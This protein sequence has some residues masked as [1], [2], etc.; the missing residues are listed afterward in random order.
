MKNFL[1][2]LAAGLFVAALSGSVT[3]VAVN[4][5]EGKTKAV[6]SAALGG[7][8]VGVAAYFKKSPLQG[9]SIQ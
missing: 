3:Q 2:N 7:A 4:L 9:N 8:L 6:G 1:K 5:Q